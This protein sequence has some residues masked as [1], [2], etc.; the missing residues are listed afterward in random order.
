M[1]YLAVLALYWSS[2]IHASLANPIIIQKNVFNTLWSPALIFFLLSLQGEQTKKYSACL[3]AGAR[4]Q[5]WRFTAGS[6]NGI[7]IQHLTTRKMYLSVHLRKRQSSQNDFQIPVLALGSPRID[8]SRLRIA[9][10]LKCWPWRASRHIT[11]SI[12]CSMTRT[13]RDTVNV[14]H[15]QCWCLAKKIPSSDVSVPRW[16]LFKTKMQCLLQHVWQSEEF[17]RIGM[18]H[19]AIFLLLVWQ[20][21]RIPLP[22]CLKPIEALSYI[23]L[24][25]KAF[26]MISPFLDVF[27]VCR[28]RNAI[29]ICWLWAIFGSWGVI[30]LGILHRVWIEQ[31]LFVFEVVSSW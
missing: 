26:L 17:Q 12:A 3:K 19:K 23:Q 15:N 2:V 9:T 13:T 25:L 10:K 11:P 5:P 8:R 14:R 22:L 24:S 7:I 4:R 30:L 20:N 16:H 31:M 18:P 21:Y 1:A 6:L 28:S 27:Q 29:C